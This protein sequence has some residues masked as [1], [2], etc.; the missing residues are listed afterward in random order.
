MNSKIGRT[1]LML[2]KY[3]HGDGWPGEVLNAILEDVSNFPDSSTVE[4]AL[5]LL[6]KNSTMGDL[7]VEFLATMA[8]AEPTSQILLS[9]GDYRQGSFTKEARDVLS[10][11]R[12]RSKV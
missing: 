8:D 7:A 5:T 3:L 1:E 10:A 12:S 9:S 2:E 4:E 6:R 11:W